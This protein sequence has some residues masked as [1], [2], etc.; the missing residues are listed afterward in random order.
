V[1]SA[2]C[3]YVVYLDVVQE[4]YKI[5]SREV[6]PCF[7]QILGGTCLCTFH[8]IAN[9][10][11][12]FKCCAEWF[13]KQLSCVL[14]CIIKLY[15]I[16][17]LCD[18]CINFMRFEDFMVVWGLNCGLLGFDSGGYKHSEGTYG[19]HLQS[20]SPQSEA[21]INWVSFITCFLTAVPHLYLYLVA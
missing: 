18:F 13:L 4:S 9:D 21:F 10:F 16:N 12:F 20:L 19:S 1:Q 7:C 14:L 15:Y 5:I 2:D 6:R 3:Y 17:V 11:M 8:S